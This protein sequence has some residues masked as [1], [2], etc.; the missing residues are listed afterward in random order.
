MQLLSDLT[1]QHVSKTSSNVAVD[2]E[3]SDEKYDTNSTMLDSFYDE[4]ARD[5]IRAIVSLVS[6]EFNDIGMAV[7]ASDSAN[8]NKRREKRFC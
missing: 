6:V 1:N 3:T 2:Y 4:R 5:A 8:W 7:S